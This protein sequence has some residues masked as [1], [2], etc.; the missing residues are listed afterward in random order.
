MIQI[1]RVA[2]LS[3]GEGHLGHACFQRQYGISVFRGLALRLTRKHE[4]LAHV[5]DVLLALLD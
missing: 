2:L 1:L 4:H 3:D 5:I